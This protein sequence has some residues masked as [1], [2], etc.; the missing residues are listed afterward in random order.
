MAADVAETGELSAAELAGAEDV[1]EIK[2]VGMLL[3][4]VATDKVVSTPAEV[5]SAFGYALVHLMSR[6]EV[7]Y[8]LGPCERVGDHKTSQFEVSQLI[9][10][11]TAL[12]GDLQ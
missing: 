5:E 4:E 6:I 12:G 8:S 7:I 11:K 9:T 3:A 2:V 10:P 1:T